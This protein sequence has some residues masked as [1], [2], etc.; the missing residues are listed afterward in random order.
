MKQ[1]IFIAPLFLLLYACSSAKKTT[2]SAYALNGTWKP[3]KQEMGGTA[4]PAAFLQAQELVILDSSY[5]LTA[6]SVDKG[7]LFYKDGKMDIYS[8]EGV[9]KGKHFTAIYKLEQ[10]Q[11]IICY[12]LKGDGYPTGFETASAPALFLSVFKRN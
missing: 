7:V 3:V 10:E 9:N 4:L 2:S 1:L 8:K 11:L 5:T 6:E 12:N